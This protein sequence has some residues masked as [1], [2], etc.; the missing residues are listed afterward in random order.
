[1]SEVIL[2][3]G[4][5]NIVLNTPSHPSTWPSWARRLLGEKPTTYAD[6]ALG[7]IATNYSEAL[8]EVLF[9]KID[10]RLYDDTMEARFDA[11]AEARHLFRER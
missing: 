5:R 6:R 10:L 2:K 11:F 1:M 7:F 9:T 8:L 4:A 3:Y